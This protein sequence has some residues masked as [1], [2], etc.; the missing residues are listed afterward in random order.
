MSIEMK[1]DGKGRFLL[2]IGAR[3]IHLAL[4]EVRWLRDQIKASLSRK[5]N[6]SKGRK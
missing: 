2:R 5:L 3:T 1:P 6:I 4:W